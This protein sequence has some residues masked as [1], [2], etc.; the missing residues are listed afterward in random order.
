MLRKCMRAR[1]SPMMPSANSCA[2]EK[3]AITEA[4]NGKPGTLPPRTR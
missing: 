2:P 1:Y 3:I 4:R